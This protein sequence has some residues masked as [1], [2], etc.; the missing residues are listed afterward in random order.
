M[1]PTQQSFLRYPFDTLLSSAASVRVL[2]ELALHGEELTTSVLARRTKV[3]DQSVRN[4]LSTPSVSSLLRMYG[5]SRAA[6]YKL[7]REHPLARILI[8]LFQAEEHRMHH[9]REEIR[10]SAASVEPPPLAVW[11]Y[12]SVARGDDRP[13]SDVDLLFVVE[14]DATTDRD[15]NR[16]RE[17]LE[18][19]ERGQR[20]TLSVVAV[21]AQDVERLAGTEDPFWA[22]LLRDALPLIG[23]SPSD[24]LALL[25]RRRRATTGGT[26][27][28]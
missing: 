20:I 24:L 15:A 4:V 6:S 28:G 7:D 22:E 5:Q 14:D 17:A 16:F 9:I 11:M 27:H 21:S 1:R 19:T 23:K 13:N 18:H 8:D 25:K 10:K 26:S 12:G 3:T 2:R